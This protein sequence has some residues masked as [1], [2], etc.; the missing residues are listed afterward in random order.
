[1]I[2]LE[3]GL[4]PELLGAQMQAVQDLEGPD[5][6]AGQIERYR[7]MF[8]LN[9]TGASK[10]WE[11]SQNAE[12]IAD[13]TRFTGDI[14]SIRTNVDYKSDA[15]KLQDAITKLTTEGINIGHIT[16]DRVE[17]PY[18]KE[19]TE[20]M[21]QIHEDLQNKYENQD[22]A[23]VYMPIAEQLTE[24][25]IPSLSGRPAAM[26]MFMETMS[27]IY[28]YKGVFGNDSEGQ[29]VAKSFMEAI[30]DI[31]GTPDTEL[32]QKIEDFT[33]KWYESRFIFTE[34]GV[35]IGEKEEQELRNLLG[36]LTTAIDAFNRRQTNVNVYS[37]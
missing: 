27:E 36:A 31:R 18:L 1:M 32:S 37:E 23:E 10:I 11:M 26:G 34:S 7:N 15:Q 35:G 25:M 3:R 30:S 20:K 8:G 22:R 6:W 9:Y 12:F 29:N 28:N 2:T 21:Q 14:E 5:N 13:P 19:A 24:T 16:F 33:A 4:R 17:M